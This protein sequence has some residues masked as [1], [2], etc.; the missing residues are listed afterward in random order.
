MVRIT[1]ADIA[2]ELGLSK[3]AVSRALSG[4]DGVSDSTRALVVRTAERLGYA[5]PVPRPEKLD[6]QLIFHNH[7][8]ANSELA[9]Q[10]Q[11]GAQQEAAARGVPLRVGWT[12][13]I[14]E[15]VRLAER[16]GG[17]LLSGAESPGT[18]EAIRGLGR[19]MVML[20]W[21]KPLEQVDQVMAA[22]HEAGAAVG[23]FLVGL[24]HREIAYVHGVPGLRGRRERLLGLRETVEMTYRGIIHEL[25]FSAMA[26][27]IARFDAAKSAGAQITAF[28]CAH[29][30]LALTVTAELLRLGYRIPEDVTVMG[31]G[32]YSA[33]TQITPAL[34]TV[35]VPGRDMGAAAVRLLLDRIRQGARSIAPA[36]RLYLVPAIIERA[37]SGPAKATRM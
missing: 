9:V 11:G 24:G 4:K 13:E 22:D 25:R 26:D 1:L 2:T 27:F 15:V 23:D 12:H 8:P 18:I 35:R 14:A 7:N 37:S 10:I 34:T 19:P 16:S 20:G 21:L 28:F 29:D 6:L 3:F 33:A 17:V 36:Q 30:G 31:F 5:R 32:D